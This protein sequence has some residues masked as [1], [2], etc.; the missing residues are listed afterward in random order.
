M[1]DRTLEAR[2]TVRLLIVIGAALLVVGAASVVVIDRVLDGSDTSSTRALVSGAR[3]TLRRELDEGDPLSEAVDEA[4][5]GA[6]SARGIRLT[7]RLPGAPPRA[8]GS[9]LPALTP[10][11]CTTLSDEKGLAWRACEA[12]QGSTSLVE[13]TSIAQ[14]RDA[15]AALARGM[16]GVVLLALLGLWFAVKGAVRAPVAELAALVGWTTRIVGAEKTIPPPSSST[17]EIAQ[18][19][20]AF[21]ELVHRLLEVLARERTSS[22]HIAHELRTPLT[23]ILAELDTLPRAS[24]A[25]SAVV[26]RI[27]ADVIKLADAIEAILVLSS[28]VA[29]RSETVVNVADLARELAPGGTSLEAPDEALV[30]ADEPLICLA[31]RNLIDNA[32]RH[33]HG[34]RAIALSRSGQALRVAVV[35]EGPGLDQAAR[36][37]MFDRY[38]RGSADGEGRGLGLALVKAVAERHGG[39]ARA[40]VGP[41]GRGLCVSMTLGRLVGWH[42]SADGSG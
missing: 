33:G 41:S 28:S 30:E 26:S 32:Q 7:V 38:W 34:V 17:R 12:S 4:L 29:P 1:D 20:R 36:D 15:V 18:L 25:S 9:V 24:Q 5:A 23:A 31:L 6:A 42:A 10:D 21:E 13:A 14:H 16:V 35:D 19:G 11:A 27:R 3:D 8:V 39:A 2:L 37:R 40:D 22:A